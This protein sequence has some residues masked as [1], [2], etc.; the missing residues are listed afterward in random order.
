VTNAIPE[1]FRFLSRSA[2]FSTVIAFGMLPGVAVRTCKKG[3]NAYQ[4][5][6]ASVATWRSGPKTGR[7]QPTIASILVLRAPHKFRFSSVAAEKLWRLVH[8]AE[9]RS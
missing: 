5:L 4:A 9:N 2:I 7:S 8:L 3:E 6:Y 1:W